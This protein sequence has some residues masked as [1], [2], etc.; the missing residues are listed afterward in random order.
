M[1]S[2]ASNLSGGNL[3]TTRDLFVSAFLLLAV[4]PPLLCAQTGTPSSPGV[5]TNAPQVTVVD[6]IPE[7]LSGETDNDSEPNI[8]IN[9]HK[10]KGNC[11][12][13]FYPGTNASRRYR[14]PIFRSTDGGNSW[15]LLSIVP[16]P[17]ITCDVTLRYG[18]SSDVLYVAALRK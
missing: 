1:R 3:L 13:G 7:S 9:P 6:I 18:S 14:A 11:R 4:A 17:E 8:A 12:V 10:P 16:S 5:A 15:S 2:P